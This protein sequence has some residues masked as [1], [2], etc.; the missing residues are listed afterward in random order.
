M[1]RKPPRSHG[2]PLVRALSKLGLAS[3]SEA[4]QLIA[5]G[6]VS[7]DHR[8]VTD[9]ATRVVPERVRIEI[10]GT[11][12][13][14]V[15]RA[16][17]LIAFHKPRGTVTTRRDPQGRP[18]VFDALG[19][20]GRGLIAVG[21]LDR[22]STGLL[23]FTNDTQL[24]N[25]LTDP[26]NKILRRYIVTVR[27]RVAPETVTALERGIEA[28]GAGGTERLRAARIEIRKASGRETHLVVNLIEGK[29]REIR[30]LFD[31][32]GHDV[33]RVHRIAFGEFELG[34]LQPRRW[35]VIE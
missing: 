22:A 17:R 26:V 28:P 21:R 14:R 34:D 33:T 2:V 15:N 7:V 19:D 8:I 27:G 18:T 4:R 9:G 10:D 31:A 6:R 35:R 30:R 25:R 32:A 12:A 16:R 11:P 29:N 5:A 23:L 13:P 1:T 24:A 20:A 3:R